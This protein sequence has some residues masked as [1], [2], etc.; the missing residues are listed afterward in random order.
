MPF[1]IM[2]SNIFTVED[3]GHMEAGEGDLEGRVEQT[4]V[5]P[6][7]VVHKLPGHRQQRVLQS[8]SQVL[9]IYKH[10]LCKL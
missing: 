10:Q 7:G 3:R 2:R 6:E 9:E 8:L 1:D 5:G 4:H